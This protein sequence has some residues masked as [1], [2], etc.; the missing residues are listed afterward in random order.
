MK[1]PTHFWFWEKVSLKSEDLVSR[2]FADR[3]RSSP[4]EGGL[5]SIEWSDSLWRG[6]GILYS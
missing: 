3:Q 6:F 5:E 4:L 1:R 2:C